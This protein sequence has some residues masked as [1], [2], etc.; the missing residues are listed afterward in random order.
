[1]SSRYDDDKYSAASQDGAD[2]T[3]GMDIPSRLPPKSSPKKHRHH[4]TRVS[5]SPPEDGDDY[6]DDDGKSHVSAKSARSEVSERTANTRKIL[7]D[8]SFSPKAGPY[9]PYAD[10][11]LRSPPITQPPVPRSTTRPANLGVDTTYP[12]DRLRPPPSGPS[13][14]HEDPGRRYSRSPG[15]RSDRRETTERPSP[16]SSV[17]RGPSARGPIQSP[18]SPGQDSRSDQ[19]GLR[20]P[21]IHMPQLEDYIVPS[22]SAKNSPQYGETSPRDRR[23]AL[24]SGY[25]RPSHPNTADD[26]A[27]ARVKSPIVQAP[28]GGSRRSSRVPY[29][30][31]GNDDHR[32]DSRTSASSASPTNARSYQATSPRDDASSPVSPRTTTGKIYGRNPREE[33]PDPILAQVASA[34]EYEKDKARKDSGMSRPIDMP[35]RPKDPNRLSASSQ[36]YGTSN[37]RSPLGRMPVRTFGDQDPQPG[38]RSPQSYG[39]Q[40]QFSPTNLDGRQRKEDSYFASRSPSSYQSQVNQTKP[41]P[42]AVYQDPF[43]ENPEEAQEQDEQ[44]IVERKRQPRLPAS[45]ASYDH[46]ITDLQ[47]EQLIVERK[48]QPRAPAS[49]A[50]YEHSITDLRLA[51]PRKPPGIYTPLL[52]PR[53]GS[54]TGTPRSGGSASS[55]VNELEERLESLRKQHEAMRKARETNLSEWQ[56]RMTKKMTTYRREMQ[57]ELRTDFKDNTDLHR[58]LKDFG[59]KLG[60]AVE[61]NEEPIA[62]LSLD[63][64]DAYNNHVAE[65]YKK[66]LDQGIPELPSEDVDVITS[67][68]FREAKRDWTGLIEDPGCRVTTEFTLTIAGGKDTEPVTRQRRQK[69]DDLLTTVPPPQIFVPDI[70]VPKS[71]RSGSRDDHGDRRDRRPE[72]T[73]DSRHDG[74][75]RGN[76]M[77]AYDSRDA[78]G[79]EDEDSSLVSSSGRGRRAYEE[80]PR[81]GT[82][83]LV[84]G[85]SRRRGNSTTT[86]YVYDTS[87]GPSKA[88]TREPS[89]EPSGRGS[90]LPS[91]ATSRAPSRPHSREPSRAPPKHRQRRTEG[92]GESSRK[93]RSRTERTESEERRRDRR[94]EDRRSRH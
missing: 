30:E 74:G 7:R 38:V 45:P 58:C 5:E 47:D 43:A 70:G 9:N 81:K 77:I 13:R 88:G 25:T 19:Y 60:T 24:P 87:R 85:D 55:R 82:L 17:S 79:G 36:G 3:G 80:V 67:T 61:K 50:S 91:G 18:T 23:D 34:T 15:G 29:P 26:Y 63:F 83:L 68:E 35:G 4:R 56:T 75:G 14:K 64:T 33:R 37:P 84:P 51:H 28:G 20:F 32:R 40:S 52:S 21:K 90:R 41:R 86:K 12:S 1:M 89:K 65:I 54:G 11:P 66:Y 6:E 39:Q 57:E 46:S 49:P 10:L 71:R 2:M 92:S 22:A 73:Y 93:H 78:E 59:W 48:R 62:N 94:R 31:R 8:A 69:Y 44:L 16:S 72:I 42:K 27:D 53:G 76:E